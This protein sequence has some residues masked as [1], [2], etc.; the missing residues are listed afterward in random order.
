MDLANLLLVLN[1]ALRSIKSLPKILLFNCRNNGT[2]FLDEYE[3]N[4]LEVMVVSLYVYT[5]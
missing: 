3:L 1:I 5:S 4:E 2:V